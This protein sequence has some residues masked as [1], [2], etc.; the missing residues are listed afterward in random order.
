MHGWPF[1]LLALLPV[2]VR[3]GVGGLVGGGRSEQK[4]RY[5]LSG[6]GTEDQQIISQIITPQCKHGHLRTCQM[7]PKVGGDKM[8]VVHVNSLVHKFDQAMKQ[9][10]IKTELILSVSF[11]QV[12]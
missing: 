5:F 1:L 3:R 10:L 9:V 6:C 12:G 2:C 8:L 11:L 4:G 7:F